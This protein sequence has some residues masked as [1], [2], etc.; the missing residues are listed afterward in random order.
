MW[1]LV[2]HQPENARLPA[3]HDKRRARQASLRRAVSTAYYAVFQALSA[4]CADTL[5][6]WSKPWEAFTPVFR[7]LEH[8]RA[9]HTLLQP[10][11]ATTP[12][13]RRFGLAFRELQEAREWADY[14]PEPRPSFEEGTKSSPFT[15][16][17][18]L[19]LLDLAE[20]AIAILDHLDE[21]ARLKLAT[22]LVARTR[23]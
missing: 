8:G 10:P 21:D 2:R 9:A 4:T 7:A 18:T 11:L 5:V 22:R 16:E 19:T 14:S 15:R 12:E 1:S 3:T 17:E 6:G 20:E 13:L 23:K